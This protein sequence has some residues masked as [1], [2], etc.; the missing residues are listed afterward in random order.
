MRPVAI[1][2][3]L[4]VGCGFDA[5]EGAGRFRCEG[6]AGC[7]AGLECRAGYCDQPGGAPADAS[8][9]DA[10]DLGCPCSLWDA[11]AVPEQLD[12]DDGMS[13]EVG[14][15]FRAEVAGRIVALRHYKTALSL[16]IHVGHLWNAEGD[17][18]AE[19]QY[20]DETASGWQEAGLSAPVAVEPQRT[21]VAS[22][23]IEGGQYAADLGYF[24][25]AL[26]R[27]PLHALA[28]GVDGGNGVFVLGGGFPDQTFMSTNY[29]VDVV[30]E[31]D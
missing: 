31:D 16:G 18:L 24:V 8:Q 28:D 5:G 27:P 4:V 12:N 19:V 20:R 7:P 9:R 11:D 10:G 13:I 21:Y 6:A 23:F 22:V 30:F 25:G 2:A 1:M 14:V 26:D 3:V 17:M 29:W 15:K